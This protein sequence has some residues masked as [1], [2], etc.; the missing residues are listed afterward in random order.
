MTRSGPTPDPDIRLV[1]VRCAF[2]SMSQ[3]TMNETCA[4]VR[5]AP[6]G[7]DHVPEKFG[8]SWAC[9]SDMLR[10]ATTVPAKMRTPVRMAHSLGAATPTPIIPIAPAQ[11]CR[12]APR[13]P[14]AVVTGAPRSI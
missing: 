14:D 1:A 13:R 4:I 7:D 12:F 9:V 10:S 3:S 2:L 11:R 6:L 8:F 5:V